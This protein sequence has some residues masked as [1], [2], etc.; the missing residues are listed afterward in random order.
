MLDNAEDAHLSDATSF[1][2]LND[3][4]ALLGRI[5][6][7]CVLLEAGEATL[8]MVEKIRSLAKSA[9]ELASCGVGDAAEFLQE[10]LWIGA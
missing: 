10:K 1:N 5:L 7:D 4:C 3:D 6:D 2:V 9:T 8:Q